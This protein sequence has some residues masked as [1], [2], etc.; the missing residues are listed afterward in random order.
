MGRRDNAASLAHPRIQNQGRLRSDQI[1]AHRA[2]ECQQS[3]RL[4]QAAREIQ[5]WS[6]R[7]RRPREQAIAC[8]RSTFGGDDGR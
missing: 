5:T 3:G 7:S 4:E 6:Q 1:S 8:G 2:C